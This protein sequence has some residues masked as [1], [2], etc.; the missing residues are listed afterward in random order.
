MYPVISTPIGLVRRLPVQ[1]SSLQ[2]VPPPAAVEVA[3][4]PRPLRMC[5]CDDPLCPCP[6]QFGDTIV[7]LVPGEPGRHGGVVLHSHPQTATHHLYFTAADGT[8][9]RATEQGL[10]CQDVVHRGVYRTVAPLCET[11]PLVCPHYSQTCDHA[12]DPD[13]TVYV[14]NKTGGTFHLNQKTGWIHHK[15]SDTHWRTDKTRGCVVWQHD[16]PEGGKPLGPPY[17]WTGQG[18]AP[19]CVAEAVDETAAETA[20]R[21]MQAVHRMLYAGDDEWA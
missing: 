10:Q 21:L 20:E 8:W 13:A 3:P 1:T 5:D 18:W 17:W 14:C 12:S 19:L 7:R 15:T 4:G 9:W 6:R 2:V 11:V 16:A